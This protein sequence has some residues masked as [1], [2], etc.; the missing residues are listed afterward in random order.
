MKIYFPYQTAPKGPGPF[1]QDTPG[2]IHVVDGVANLDDRN[3]NTPDMAN[4]LVS[5]YGGSLEPLEKKAPVRVVPEYDV[6]EVEA[7]EAP[8]GRSRK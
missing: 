4:L 2:F 3:P 6:P 1:N 7:E 8:K 5:S